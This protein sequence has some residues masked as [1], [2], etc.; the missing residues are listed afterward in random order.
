M[1]ASLFTPFRLKNREFKNRVIAAPP[2]SL[3]AGADGTVQPP[4]LTYYHNLADTD[5]GMVIVEAA[6]ISREAC[7]WPDQLGMFSGSMV[8]GLSRLVERIRSRGAVPVAQLFH[9]GINAI[10]VNTVVFGPSGIQ[11]RKISGKILE[12]KKEK[13]VQLANDY[14]EAARIAWDAG[15]SGIEIQA[16]DG[17]LPQQFMSPLSNQRTD[18]YAFAKAG[19]ILFLQQMVRA[20]KRVVPDLMLLVS[21]S[22]RDLIPAGGGLHSAI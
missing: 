1:I 7:S 9:G 10:P 12:I 11:H 20:V 22:M 18:D 17:S 8:S 16:A 4:M 2:P 5:A 19:G 3:L 21:M 6:A 14:A 15:F 13:F